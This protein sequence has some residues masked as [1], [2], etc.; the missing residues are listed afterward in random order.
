MASP[1]PHTPSDLALAPV[2][3]EIERNLARLRS[4]HDLQYDLALDLNDDE[5]FYSSAPPRAARLM[6][7]ALRDVDTH[8]WE[9]CPTSDLCGLLVR[10]GSYSVSLMFGRHLTD[11]VLQP[12]LAD[13]R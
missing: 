8:G 10:H 1:H 13:A 2:L 11:Y 3:I 7:S 5:T 9:V 6:H 12:E 4:S